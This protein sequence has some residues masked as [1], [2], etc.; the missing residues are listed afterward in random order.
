M[1]LIFLVS[2]ISSC[3]I[4]EIFASLLLKIIYFLKKSKLKKTFNINMLMGE[5][6]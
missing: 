1:A 5:L 3:K 2:I 6:I 4:E